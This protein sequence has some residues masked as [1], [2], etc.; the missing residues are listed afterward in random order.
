VIGNSNWPLALN[1]IRNASA[2]LLKAYFSNLY[3]DTSD[4]I[5][6][7]DLTTDEIFLTGYKHLLT[8]NSHDKAYAFAQSLQLSDINATNELHLKLV[9]KTLIQFDQILRC[10]SVDLW[11]LY[12]ERA[13]QSIPVLNITAKMAAIRTE[14]ATSSTALAISKATDIFNDMQMKNCETQLRLANLEKNFQCQEQK[15]N[16]ITKKINMKKKHTHKRKLSTRAYDLSTTKGSYPPT[17]QQKTKTGRPNDGTRRGST[18]K[19]RPLLQKHKTQTKKPTQIQRALEQHREFHPMEVRGS[20]SLQ[21]QQ[22]CHHLKISSTTES[23]HGQTKPLY[24]ET[25]LCFRP[26]PQSFHNPIRYSICHPQY[27]S[28]LG[29]FPQIIY[30]QPLGTNLNPF[31]LF[32]QQQI[33]NPHNKPN[34]NSRGHHGRR[35]KQNQRK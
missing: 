18:T 27:H 6:F 16:E 19:K 31:C 5:Q 7:L 33:N 24:T 14:N 23:S 10:S 15:T 26:T 17:K 13:K 12:K 20:L 9:Y 22:T 4:I 30:P 32:P 3:I 11:Q 35:S 25:T 29:P 1:N 21:P 2:L 34:L 28:H 8:T